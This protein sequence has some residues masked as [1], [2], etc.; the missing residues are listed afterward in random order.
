M[1]INTSNES[2]INWERIK[3]AWK[4][5]KKSI[6]EIADQYGVSV[7][8]IRYRA[9]R[10]L[11]GERCVKKHDK[12][13]EHDDKSNSAK[14]DKYKQNRNV[15]TEGVN[16]KQQHESCLS[17][18]DIDTSI[19]YICEN[20]G[21]DRIQQAIRL[22][23]DIRHSLHSSLNLFQTQQEGSCSVS[24][25]RQLGDIIRMHRKILMQLLE[26]EEGFEKYS[27]SSDSPDSPRGSSYSIRLHEAKEEIM[28]RLVGL[29]TSLEEQ[30]VCG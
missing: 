1:V 22:Y 29:H 6:P 5:S 18:Y 14:Q 20:R 24:Q 19:N 27:K 16:R 15:C 30:G 25:L 7:S 3:S 2:K 26:Y 4:R 8:A 12:K 17:D 23:A 9:K 10:Y 11:W 21:E 13:K 28:G